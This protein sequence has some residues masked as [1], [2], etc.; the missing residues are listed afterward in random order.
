MEEENFDVKS[1][2]KILE[3]IEE[4]PSTEPE[5]TISK[6]ITVM[7]GNPIPVL[8]IGL[9]KYLTIEAEQK[10]PKLPMPED[11]TKTEKILHEMLTENTGAHFLDSGFLYGRHWEENRKIQD[12]RKTPVIIVEK[13]YVLVNIFHFLNAFL[14]RDA[15]SEILEAYFYKLAD[16]EWINLSW[17]ECIYKFAKVLRKLGFET[18]NVF[19]TY[20]WENL[21]SQGF[22]GMIF[23]NEKGSYIILQIHN[24]CDVRGGYTKPRIFKLTADLEFEF[25]DAMNDIHAECKC[26]NAYIDE[27]FNWHWYSDYEKDKAEFPEYWEWNE[28]EKVF[29]C[30]KCNNKVEFY[31]CLI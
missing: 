3:E 30:K 1:I 6:I 7:G 21:L 14:E 24:G 10:N 28:K 12:F 15:V 4:I 27:S 22:Q 13:D 29:V 2:K 26:T 17:L 20:N 31:S 23:E 9:N 18:Y 8:S 19:N 25:H 16:T 11:Y 5:K